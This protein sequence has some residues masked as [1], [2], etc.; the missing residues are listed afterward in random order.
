MLFQND[1]RNTAHRAFSCCQLREHVSAV[2]VVIDHV[3]HTI[4]LAYRAVQPALDIALDLVAAWRV[5]VVVGAF[6]LGHGRFPSLTKRSC[7]FMAHYTPRGYKSKLESKNCQG[8]LAHYCAY[9]WRRSASSFLFLKYTHQ[10]AAK[11]MQLSTYT[12]KTQLMVPTVSFAAMPQAYPAHISAK[13][14]QLVPAAV[15]ALYDFHA[16]MGHETPK[17]TNMPTSSNSARNILSPSSFFFSVFLRYRLI[18]IASHKPTV[19]YPIILMRFIPDK[20]LLVPLLI[21]V[22]YYFPMDTNKLKYFLA[23]AEDEHITNA[24]KRL[25]IA[26][27]A[28]TRALHKLESELGVKLFARN[29]RNIKLTP[30][31]E[32]LKEKTQAAMT[33]IE[34]AERTIRLFSERSKT[35]IRICILAASVIVIDAI[36][37]YSLR[38]PEISFEVSQEEK[39]SFADITISSRPTS[40]KEKPWF[41]ERIGIATQ[42]SADIRKGPVRKEGPIRL[43]DLGSKKF[44]ALSEPKDI[45]DQCDALCTSNGFTPNIIFES[46]NPSVV[47]KMIG[48]G[49]GIGFWPEI[50]WGDVGETCVW[51]PLA[52]DGFNRKVFAALTPQGFEKECARDFKN[53]LDH[54]D[55]I[56]DGR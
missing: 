16:F 29:G 48:L 35:T 54:C 20:Y 13:N 17:H 11:K 55:R 30:A 3:L 28:L 12:P 8:Q 32:L 47:R 41:T 23:V 42:R 15:R 45:R 33:E 5:L 46:E 19:R 56:S 18:P 39:A 21:P 7:S 2:T 25:S 6:A 44:I 51:F 50:S 52:D 1:L 26:Q 49:M 14:C 24:S 31:G 27:P 9:F 37:D 34:E 43:E 22:C 38:H 4:E 53:F 36:A 10:F 40:S